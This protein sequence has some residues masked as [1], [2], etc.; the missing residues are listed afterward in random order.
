MS[1]NFERHLKLID[2]DKRFNLLGYL[3]SDQFDG[4]IQFASYAGDDVFD[5]KESKIHQRQSLLKTAEELL[6]FLNSRNSVFTSITPLGRID[7]P[8]MNPIAPRELV[9]NALVHNDCR[10][11]GLPTFEEFPHR[12]EISSS[13]AFRRA[14]PKT[15]S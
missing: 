5:L 13:E 6:D 10:S 3:V 9:I 12:F 11:G 7:E 1:D 2:E 8:K 4:P 15:I 14:F